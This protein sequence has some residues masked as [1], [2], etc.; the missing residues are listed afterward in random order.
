MVGE[1]EENGVEAEVGERREGEEG[2]DR[3]WAAVDGLDRQTAL[4]V[5]RWAD[6]DGVSEDSVEKARH[7]LLQDP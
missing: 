6:E 1:E 2:G 7:S 4:V 3:A 5:E